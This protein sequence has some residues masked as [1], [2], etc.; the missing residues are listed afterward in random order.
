MGRCVAHK[1]SNL[2]RQCDRRAADNEAF[3]RRLTT[4]EEFQKMASILRISPQDDRTRVN[5]GICILLPLVSQRISL[6]Q[7]R[8]QLEAV[9]VAASRLHDSLSALL[10]GNSKAAVLLGL[11]IQPLTNWSYDDIE[12]GMT[13]GLRYLELGIAVMDN[14]TGD[15]NKKSDV[16]EDISMAFH[17]FLRH[18]EILRD[19]A[20]KTIIDHY[21][22]PQRMRG[23]P[24]DWQRDKL[25]RGAAAI[26]RKFRKRRPTL[27]TRPPIGDRTTYG[28]EFYELA[29][30]MDGAFLRAAGRDP[31]QE[32]QIGS[33][34]KRF[35]LQ[36]SREGKKIRQ[37]IT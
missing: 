21:N 29:S 7:Q 13:L 6:R 5:I 3:L 8:D 36:E 35:M 2:K 28:G 25:V 17:H 37:N 20:A 4:D 1:N 26:Y 23:R 34:L 27:T 24:P 16:A 30:T 18:C 33:V 31:E 19:A 22:D 32:T 15:I 10:E 11:V 14:V 9:H 12:D